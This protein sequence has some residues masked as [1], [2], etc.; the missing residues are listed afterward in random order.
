MVPLKA[1]V[2]VS[3]SA[4]SGSYPIILVSTVQEQMSIAGLDDSQDNPQQEHEQNDSAMPAPSKDKQ[5]KG[6]TCGEE[7][8][9]PYEAL[10]KVVEGAEHSSSCGGGEIVEQATLLTILSA[11]KP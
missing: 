2:R 11:Y 7:V 6:K 3:L 10:C 1:G 8:F 9:V 5:G 4:R